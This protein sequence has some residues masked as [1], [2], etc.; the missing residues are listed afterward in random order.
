MNPL[1]ILLLNV[2]ATLVDRPRAPV[3]R[4]AVI[5]RWCLRRRGSR[6]QGRSGCDRRRLD[7][8]QTTEMRR[9]GPGESRR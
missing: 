9:C 7:S 6:G 3:P 1:A 8:R 4:G 5:R 2:T